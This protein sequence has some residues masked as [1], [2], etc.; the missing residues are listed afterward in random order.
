MFGALD[1]IMAGVEHI[2][3]PLHQM[4]S[5]LRIFSGI[6]FNSK[7][8]TY[9][10]L[11]LF[12]FTRFVTATF[13]N[14]TTYDPTYKSKTDPRS[15]LIKVT[16]PF[17]QM[18]QSPFNRL[19]LSK[20]YE[21]Y[22]SLNQRLTQTYFPR[23]YDFLIRVAEAPSEPVRYDPPT[24]A[25]LLDSLAFIL[26][27]TWKGYDQLATNYSDLMSNPA[28]NPPISWSLAAFF[29]RFFKDAPDVPG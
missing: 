28:R 16:I 2:P 3:P 4:A 10:T 5:I 21:P 7:R 1:R 23:L 26:E 29:M 8:A 24:Q 9:N 12:F 13:A 27:K 11:S 15:F 18:M 20:K 25:Q 14:P 6:R 19:V 17:S 22:Q